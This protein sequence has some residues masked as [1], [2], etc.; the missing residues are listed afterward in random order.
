MRLR[1]T[2]LTLL[3]AAALMGAV[4]VLAV[5]Y[6]EM[7][8]TLPQGDP[9][10]GRRAFLDLGCASCHRV[11][12]EQDLPMPVSAHPGPFLGAVLAGR[13]PGGLASSIVSP[14]HQVPENLRRT[15]ED[16]LSPMGDYTQVMTVRQL[17]DLVAYLRSIEREG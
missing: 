17:A 11:V 12:G 16:E 1:D 5:E 10:A 4:A 7:E 8:L 2:G 6:Q 13:E 9:A 3:A 14:S 15:T